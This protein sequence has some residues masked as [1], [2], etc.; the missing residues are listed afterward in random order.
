MAAGS[1]SAAVGSQRE[2][3][4]RG[5]RD[6]LREHADVVIDEFPL[7]AAPPYGF[8]ARWA[9]SRSQLRKVEILSSET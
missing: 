4:G 8:G 5:V 2:A 1:I 9:W 6:G 3:L 7:P